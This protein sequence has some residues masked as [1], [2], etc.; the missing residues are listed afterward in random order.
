[1]EPGAFGAEEDGGTR[2]RRE[3]AEGNGVGTGRQGE[4]GEAGIVKEADGIGPV[5]EGGEG[6]AER[7]AH[8][9]AEGLAVEGM[10]GA[11]G[12]ED[13]GAIDHASEVAEDG[14]DVLDVGEV[15]ADD[16]EL[17]VGEEGVEGRVGEALAA[18]EDA[19]VEGEPRDGFHHGRFGDEDGDGGVK[20]GDGVG[21]AAL[22]EGGGEEEGAEGEA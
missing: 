20:G 6:D 19:S 12:E 16:D 8:G 22:G 7:V 13:G 3:V 9:D 4:G 14:T 2:R 1:M 21:E 18:G 11:R 15:L 17:G 5:G 10:A